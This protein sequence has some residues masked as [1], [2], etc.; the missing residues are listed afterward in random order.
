MSGARLICV[1]THHKTGTIWMRKVWRAIA[2]AQDIPFMQCYRAK[3]LADVAESGPQIIVNWSSSFPAELFARE[4]A[5]FIHI[6]RDPRD[7]LLSGMRYHRVAPL[8]NEKFLRERREAWG[9]G[10]YQDHLNALPDDHARLMF[11]M[12]EKH[13]KTVREMLAW[14]WGHDRAHELR[15]EDLIRDTECRLF[16]QV[17][18]ACD[19][20]GL[21]IDGAVRS[22]WDLSLFGGLARE[23]DRSARQNLHVN[24]GAEAQ[25]KGKLPP[26]IARVYAE[27]YGPA[28]KSLGYAADDS[29][30]RELSAERAA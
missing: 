1:G 14:P 17:L 16:R 7:V 13:D 18:E 6:V 30:L 20:E 2:R 12:E 25:W 5:R 26:E 27:R 28:L 22:F 15:Y 21:D 8:G 19:I 11:E 4:D 10:T 23:D 9:G 3:R 24:S 29:W